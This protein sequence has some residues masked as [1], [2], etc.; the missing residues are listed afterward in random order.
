MPHKHG[1]SF[2]AQE[3]KPEHGN[4]KPELRF[5]ILEFRFGIPVLGFAILVLR[6]GIPVLRFGKPEPRF[7][8]PVFEFAKPGLILYS[9][10]RATAG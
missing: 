10:R 9:S 3:A 4:G 1:G 2:R 5:A 6:F 7:A 8:I